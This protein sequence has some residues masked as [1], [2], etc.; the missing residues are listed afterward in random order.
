VGVGK[1]DMERGSQSHTGAK[2]GTQRSVFVFSQCVLASQPWSVGKAHMERVSQSHT[3]AK[4]GTQR[5]ILSSH[6]A[7]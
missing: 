4:V 6:I 3:G 5:S 7:Y 2:V 1:A